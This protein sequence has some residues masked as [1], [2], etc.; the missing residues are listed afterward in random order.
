MAPAPKPVPKPVTISTSDRKVFPDLVVTDL[1]PKAM[2]C[3]G[4]ARDLEVPKTPV[5]QPVK[6]V[7]VVKYLQDSWSDTGTEISAISSVEDV[8][9]RD[10]E[11]DEL[12]EMMYE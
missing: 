12:E 9:R 2:G 7:P 3:W 5:I 8:R 11:L 4:V 1:K 10:A 6:A